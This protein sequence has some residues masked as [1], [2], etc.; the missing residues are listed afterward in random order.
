MA[1]L[2]LEAAAIGGKDSMS[3]SFEQ[4]HVPP[5]L[6]SFAVAA[7]RA[8]NIISNEFKRPGAD[9]GLLLPEYGEDG[10]PVA[11]SLRALFD[12]SL[13]HISPARSARASSTPTNNSIRLPFPR[14]A[15]WECGLKGR[16]AWRERSNSN[17]CLLYTSRCV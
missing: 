15:P 4:M 10:L 14:R 7:C 5:T 3:G 11:K 12:L 9:V 13:I 8:E 6:V 1:Q 17:T 16:E 2:D